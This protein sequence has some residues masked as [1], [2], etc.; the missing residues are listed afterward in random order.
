M[1]RTSKRFLAML[2]SCLMF[3]TILTVSA[4][5]AP[6]IE[7][8]NPYEHVDWATFGQ[9]RAALHTHTTASDGAHTLAEM[10]EAYF[11]A[12]YDALAITD[13]G[14]V[15]RCWINPNSK[16]IQ[17]WADNFLDTIWPRRVVR[18]AGLTP[19]R[20]A[21]IN[22]GYGRDGR[23]MIR[24]PLGNEQNPNGSSNSGL[25]HV[26]SW[27]ADFGHGLPGGRWDISVAVRGVHRRGGLS[28]V[29]HPSLMLQTREINDY[30]VNKVQR[31]L[32]RYDSLIGIE[33]HNALDRYLWDT[34]LT[35]LAPTGR[36]VF[37]VA[38]DDAHNRYN[39]D[40][41]WVVALMPENTA[42][43]LKTS[44]ETGAIF[45][46][47]RS[48]NQ[49]D[50]IELLRAEGHI[51]A[52]ESW[53]ANRE[54][55]APAVTN[56]TANAGVITLETENAEVIA[57][58]ADGEIVATGNELVLANYID[59]IGAYVRAEVW[60]EGGI[61]YTQPFLLS[62]EGMPAGRPVPSD[63]RSQGDVY[64]FFRTLMIPFRS[65]QF[66]GLLFEAIGTVVRYDILPFLGLS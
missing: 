54:H 25:I 8:Q 15:D 44:M 14:V 12:G 38:A 37:A 66:I 62:Y 39:I 40:R 24:V 50:L 13:H 64:A 32:E 17:P 30:I 58:V 53:Q 48:F 51:E 1:N 36:N 33:M 34:L 16:P 26:T 42:E 21:Q 22:A 20:Y 7:I 61:L 60:G 23:G 2:L 56:I 65:V 9:Y 11:A 43:N 31:E 6:A 27:F 5:A 4:T 45:A 46:L 18:G 63:F 35:N 28:V 19:E 49:P 10:V 59:D 47:N 52:T 55:P 41:R 29:A 3:A 57:W